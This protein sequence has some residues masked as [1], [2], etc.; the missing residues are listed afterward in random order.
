MYKLDSEDSVRR[1]RVAVE[2]RG[3]GSGDAQSEVEAKVEQSRTI[4][5]ES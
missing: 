1:G 2:R 5:T 4:K 3:K